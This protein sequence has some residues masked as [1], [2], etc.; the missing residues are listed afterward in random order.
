MHEIVDRSLAQSFDNSNKAGGDKG[1][2]NT[3]NVSDEHTRI[4]ESSIDTLEALGDTPIKII[5]HI[6]NASSS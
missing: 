4:T 6:N 1:D 3:K 5:P 2:L